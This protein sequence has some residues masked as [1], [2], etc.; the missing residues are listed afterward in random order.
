[1]NM[2]RAV[3]MMVLVLF[4]ALVAIPPAPAEASDAGLIVAAVV[5]A[6]GAPFIVAKL[7]IDAFSKPE[8]EKEKPAAAEDD[9]KKV[10]TAD[11]EQLIAE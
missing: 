5:V 7:L 1:M 3:A 9:K 11:R 4:L 8:S 6:L 10:T 2:K